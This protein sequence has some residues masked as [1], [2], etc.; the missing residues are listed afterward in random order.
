[1]CGACMLS[2]DMLYSPSPCPSALVPV[3]LAGGGGGDTGRSAEEREGGAVW[4]K[5]WTAGQAAASLPP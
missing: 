3:G 4:W 2:E 1:V 5:V